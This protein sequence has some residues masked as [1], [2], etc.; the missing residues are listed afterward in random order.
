MNAVPADHDPEPEP[1]EPA[2]SEGGGA[3]RLPPRPRAPASVVVLATL[4]I[5]AT[6]WAAQALILPILLAAFFALQ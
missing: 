6:L 5:G 1:T 2:P 4:A 3:R